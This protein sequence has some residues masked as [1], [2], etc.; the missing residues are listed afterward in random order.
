VAANSLAWSVL[1][2][3]TDTVLSE[4]PSCSAAAFIRSKAMAGRRASA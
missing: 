1:V 2:R 4:M 3:N